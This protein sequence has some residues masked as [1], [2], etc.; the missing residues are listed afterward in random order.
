[1]IHKNYI[2]II[3][4]AFP[5]ILAN[6]AVPLLGLA[7]TAAIGQTGAAVDLGAIALASLIFNFVYWGFGFLRMGTTGF[8]SQAAGANDVDET[9]ALLFRAVLLGAGIGILLIILQRLIGE[10]A[11]SLLKTSAEIKTLVGDYFYI[12][13]WGAPATLI[14]FTLLGTFIGMGWTKHLLIVQLFL[15]GL[16]ILLNVL[17]VV[18]YDFGVRGIALGT[19]LAEWSTL[20]FASYLL[21]KKMQLGHL[22]HRFR[23]LR[24]LVF[25]NAKLLALVK[26]NGDIMIRTLALLTGF[27]WFANQGADFGDN[28]LAANH[29]LLQF[30]S[31]SAFF[32]DGYAHV[33]EMLTGNADGARNKTLFAQQV[34][35][36]SVLA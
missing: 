35:H 32:L 9:H 1:M 4:L 10:T 16:N 18:G 11:I 15:N 24:E 34:R 5:V 27:A 29:V 31:L 12:R 20:F 13:I 3:K 19:V 8:I 22:G 23:R 28:V 26:V 33:A 25:N 2:R 14:T 17:F 36:S 21:V 7:D 6:A 30:V